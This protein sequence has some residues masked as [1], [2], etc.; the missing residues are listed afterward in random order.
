MSEWMMK[1]NPFTIPQNTPVL[2]FPFN[3]ETRFYELNFTAL[4]CIEEQMTKISVLVSPVDV[5]NILF[6]FRYDFK[7]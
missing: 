7:F 4:V 5:R 3:I 6:S 2:L 1:E